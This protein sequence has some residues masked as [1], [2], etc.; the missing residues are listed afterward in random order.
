MSVP[1]PCE[2]VILTPMKFTHVEKTPI[3]T[4]RYIPPSQKTDIKKEVTPLTKE[5]MSSTNMFPS[6]LGAVWKENKNQGATSMSQVIGAAI[7]REKKALEA[8]NREK[9]LE[10]MSDKQ[11]LADGWNIVNLENTSLPDCSITDTDALYLQSGWGEEITQI[12]MHQPEVFLKHVQCVY[13]DGSPI[14]RRKMRTKTPIIDTYIQS[15]PITNPVKQF[16]NLAKK[17]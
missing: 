12:M 1:K 6:L 2:G 10:K 7:E 4:G 9:D 15:T 8:E 16:W 5:D 3:K 11:L 17:N 14:E 13:E